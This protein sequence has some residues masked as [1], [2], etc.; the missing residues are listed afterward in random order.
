MDINTDSQSIILE[1]NLNNDIKTEVSKKTVYL[2]VKRIIDIIISSLGLIILSPVFLLLAII[3]KMDSKGP[4]FFAHIRV[5]KN[6]KKFKMYKFR[7][8]CDNAQKMIR[9]F[10]PEQKKEFEENYKLKDDPR[11]TRV[12]KILR[13]TSL[14]ELPQIFNI[15]IGDLSIVGPRAIITKE[16]KKY[17]DNKE[18]FLSVTPGLTGYW[19][20]NGRSNTTY[21]ERIEMELYYIDNMSFKLDLKIF[22]KTFIAVFKKEGAV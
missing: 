15:L 4:V 7:T 21:E 5:G 1:E 13:K 14:D 17:G 3:I 18:K 10:N 22:L 12:G 6:G 16:L 2:K 11:I 20:V 8:M 19:Q 9:K